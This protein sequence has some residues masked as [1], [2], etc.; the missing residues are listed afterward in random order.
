M[1]TYEYRCNSCGAEF[2]R[3]VSLREHEQERQRC[4]KCG[5]EQIVQLMS[6]FMP[7]TSR[8]A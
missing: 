2:T 5:S 3:A 1:P 7:K 4:P 8:K 6:A